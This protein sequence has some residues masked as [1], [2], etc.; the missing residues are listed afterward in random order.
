MNSSEIKMNWIENP[1]KIPKGENPAS[2]G[3][4]FLPIGVHMR[5][6]C[7]TRRMAPTEKT[8]K[9]KTTNKIAPPS[10]N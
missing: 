1:P 9:R 6:C 8:K 5:V 3:A 7:R 10:F 2:T 4:F